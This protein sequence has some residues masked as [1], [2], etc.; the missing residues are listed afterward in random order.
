[1]KPRPGNGC[2]FGGP[3]FGPVAAS[4]PSPNFPRH[5]SSILDHSNGVLLYCQTTTHFI[6]SNPTVILLFIATP[7]TGTESGQLHGEIGTPAD[8]ES[9][10]CPRRHRLL[11]R[12]SALLQL[13]EDISAFL[14]IGETS[15]TA[16]SLSLAVSWPSKAQFPGPIWRKPREARYCATQRWSNFGRTLFSLCTSH[17]TLV[18]SCHPQ[19]GFTAPVFPAT[20]SPFNK[21]QPTSPTTTT[22]TAAPSLR[23]AAHSPRLF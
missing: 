1:M 3:S 9:I 22:T 5:Q 6:A 10:P 23:L 20:N 15:R 16:F 12:A 14:F 19:F 11:L 2:S 4:P 7:Q 21:H 8:L 13:V 17:T 18:Q